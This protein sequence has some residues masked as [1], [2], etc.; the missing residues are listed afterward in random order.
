[1]KIAIIGCGLM[2]AKRASDLPKGCCLAGV[3]DIERTKAEQFAQ[4]F[5]NCT[6]F[7]APH[8]IWNHPDIDIV[9]IATPH[10]SLAPLA[11]AGIE[12]GKHLLLEKPGGTSSS[13]IDQLI[14]AQAQ[15]QVKVRLGFNHRFHPAIQKAKALVDA[16]ELGELY[17]IRGYYGHGGRLGYEQEWRM[18]KALSG[19][20]QLIDQGMHLI[21]LS[22]WFLGEFTQV[23][24][25][26]HI[27]YWQAEVEDN[28]FLQLNTAQNQTAWL[29]ASLTEWKNRFS[30]EIVG[31]C[32][33]CDIFGLGGSYGTEQLTF[34]KML[35]EMGPPETISWQYPQADHSWRLE[36]S[37]LIEDIENGRGCEPGLY[38]AK[39]S[40]A[41]VEDISYR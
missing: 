33:K 6:V 31:R 41:I 13:E 17:Y 39:R 37:A 32:G 2:A 1:M 9:V 4:G 22:R 20:G 34:Y 38:D 36:M 19:G 23:H 27:Y 10:A 28:A 25:Q 5:P 12:S 30:F 3:Y 11:L 21:D 24:G 14:A 8:E 7:K 18:N 16:G 15:T 26:K 35:P 40:L 29:H